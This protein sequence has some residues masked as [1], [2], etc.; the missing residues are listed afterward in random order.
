MSDPFVRSE[1]LQKGIDIVTLCRS[2]KRN[3]LNIAMLQQ[4]SDAIEKLQRES[5]SRILILTGEG[6]VFCAGLDLVEAAD[7]SLAE[8]SAEG[9][10][11]VLTQLRT[12]PLIVVCAA[13]GAAY[14]GGAGLLAASDLVVASD[15]FKLGFPEVRRGLVAAM[16]SAMLAGKVRDGDLREL[17]L[18]G[19]PISGRR[20]NEMGLVQWLV[21]S[22][23]VIEKAKSIARTVAIGGPQAVRETK[24]LLNGQCMATDVALLK[25]LHERVRQ[26]EEA[27]EGLAAFRE[28][29]EPNWCEKN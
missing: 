15:D 27:L 21:P 29:R 24:Q 19:E 18:L 4:L 5:H 7:V 17:L 20:A 8:E 22:D 13:V 10:R 26:S 14:A 11:K 2:D 25:E 3:A 9:V 6:S 1:N 28:R 12:T 23:Q 16:V